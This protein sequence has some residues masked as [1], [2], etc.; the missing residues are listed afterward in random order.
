MFCEF[1]QREGRVWLKEGCD[2]EGR[3]ALR[4]YLARHGKV[5][6]PKPAPAPPRRYLPRPVDTRSP[7]RRALDHIAESLARTSKAAAKHIRP[8]AP[9]IGAQLDD[10]ALAD[11]FRRK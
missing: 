7:R 8:A 9:D 3:C 1:C 10:Q 4:L 6:K 11:R 2:R 5:P